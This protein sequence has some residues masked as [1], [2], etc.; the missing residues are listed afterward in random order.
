ME[1]FTKLG[2]DWRLLFAQ[3]INFLILF[4]VL[5]KFAYKPILNFLDERKNKIEA[6]LK[7]AEIAEEKLKNAQDTEKQTIL[8][9]KKEAQQILE[10]VVVDS[11]KTKQNIIDEANLQAKKILEEAKLKTEQEKKQLITDVKK[12]MAELIVKAS[13]KVVGQKLDVN[14][15][16]E[17]VRKAIQ[18]MSV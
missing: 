9:A 13:E 2:I 1:L 6:G 15:D 8:S 16:S 17:I 14:K 11:E 3:L 7:N 5:K 4:F 12:E 18:D 10:S